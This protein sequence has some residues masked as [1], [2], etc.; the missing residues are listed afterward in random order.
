LR[1]EPETE[2]V[3][4]QPPVRVDDTA[5]VSAFREQLVQVGLNLGTCLERNR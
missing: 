5:P 4:I 3:V 2:H 1:L